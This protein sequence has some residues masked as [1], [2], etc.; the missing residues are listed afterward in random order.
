MINCVRESAGQICSVEFMLAIA[1]G[2]VE[3]YCEGCGD[4]AANEHLGPWQGESAA[5]EER[6]CC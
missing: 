4:K 2:S 6:R 1:E 3:E 5:A